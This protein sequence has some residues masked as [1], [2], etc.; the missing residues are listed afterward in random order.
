MTTL[1]FCKRLFTCAPCAIRAC[2]TLYTKWIWPIFFI[3]AVIAVVSSK[4]L[5]FSVNL[6]Y[7]DT[8]FY[9]YCAIHKK[10]DSLPEANFYRAT[11][12]VIDHARSQYITHIVFFFK[13]LYTVCKRER[14]S[15]WERNRQTRNLLIAN[16]MKNALLQTRAWN[17]R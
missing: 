6:Y 11:K 14:E 16:L 2:G 9:R 17:L 15:E 10:N 13:C 3:V 7:N 8:I 4:I 1:V 5:T 12:L